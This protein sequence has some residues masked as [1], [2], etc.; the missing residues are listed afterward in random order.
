MTLYYDDPQKLATHKP[1]AIDI[2]VLIVGGG[3]S[4]L[5]Q[6]YMLSQFG[7]SAM[8]PSFSDSKFL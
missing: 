5:L 1:C 4:G 6:A 2:P 8:A 3:P 7:G